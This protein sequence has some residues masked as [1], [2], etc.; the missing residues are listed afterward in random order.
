MSEKEPF[1]K[2]KTLFEMTPWE[3]ESLCDGCGRC[4]L[5]RLID[6]D[7]GDYHVTCLSCRFLDTETCRCT[8]Y[9]RRLSQKV[10][11]C[12]PLGPLTIG[13]Y[14]WLPKSCAYRRI[15]AGKDLQWW[16]PLVSGD[17]E[18]VHTAGISVRGKTVCET[19][20]PSEALEAYIISEKL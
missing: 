19:Y 8:A 11:E 12:L 2:R 7:T 14:Y 1:W 10:T 6:E 17:P 9:E 3:W 18:T 4:C 5:R 15:A 13:E 20:V 16:H